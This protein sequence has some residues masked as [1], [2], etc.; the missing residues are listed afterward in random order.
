MIVI[1]HSESHNSD[2]TLNFVNYSHMG[3][4]WPQLNAGTYVMARLPPIARML[5]L[6][7]KI[8]L[9]Q[10]MNKQNDKKVCHEN[11]GT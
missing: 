4:A 9:I 5:K 11:A 8:S 1:I 2:M 3:K 7:A 6:V 10:L